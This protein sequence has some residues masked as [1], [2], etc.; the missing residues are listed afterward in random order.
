MVAY[1]VKEVVEIGPPLPVGLPV[2]SSTFVALWRTLD[3]LV[4]GDGVSR[5]DIESDV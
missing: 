2:D 4:P 3:S 1:E 5:T